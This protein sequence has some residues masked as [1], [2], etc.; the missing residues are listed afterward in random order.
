MED[1]DIFTDEINF[2]KPVYT[3]IL[4]DFVKDVPATPS[5]A[6][7]QSAQRLLAEECLLENKEEC[8]FHFSESVSA[9]VRSLAVYREDQHEIT[10]AD[11]IK[12][13]APFTNICDRV[14][15]K[16][17][18]KEDDLLNTILSEGVKTLKLRSNEEIPF[19]KKYMRFG[20]HNNVKNLLKILNELPKEW[21]IVQLTAR[22]NP[23]ENV[24]PFSEYRTDIDGIFL[25]IL[26]N[27]YTDKPLTVLVP[28]NVT[29]EGELPLFKELYSILEDNYN[30]IDKAQYLNNK[31]L[32]RN[33]WS[34]RED[35]D[36]RIKSVIN[37]M[38]K[39][40]LGG[41]CSMLTGKLSDSKLRDRII[42]FVDSA[43][44]DWGF[45][46]LTAKQKIL[47][48][49]L[50]DCSPVL[51][52]QQIKSCIRQILTE[53]G[54]NEEL[55]NVRNSIKCQSC[56]NEFR[57][58]NE[59]CIKC[60]SQCFEE[61]HKFTLVDGIKAF[62][63]VA[64]KFK[65]D[66]QW[67]DLKK[68]KRGPVI[69]IVDEMLDTFPWESLPALNQQPISRIENIHF[70]YSLFKT[71]EESIKNGYFVTKS[72]I[73]RYVINPGQDLQRMQLRMES[74]I[75]Y[76]CG[77]WEGRVAEPPAPGELLNYLT[78][79]DIFLYCGHGDGCG[80]V[81][82]GSGIGA[83]AGRC[84]CLLSGCGSVRLSGG[85][86]RAPPAGPH[87]H[88]HVAKC[89]CVVGMLWEV[90][91]LEVDKVV[92]TLVALSVASE[93]PLDWRHVGK[94]K[95]SQGEIDVSVEQK[96]RTPPE[97][98]LLRAICRAKQATNFLMIS[99]SIVARGLPIKIIDSNPPNSS[100]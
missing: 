40:W 63:Q 34:R 98:N 33:Y 3:N 19:H 53:N 16:S 5:S 36:L 37:V 8:E 41:W 47:L 61:I 73:G 91:D 75:K 93:A 86:G 76:W 28:A 18:D 52:S 83:G 1:F 39:D 87:H 90:T 31:R 80:S 51:Q 13:I 57:F 72:E 94:T 92:S 55:R 58:P 54:N 100:V 64:L 97:R 88:L 50:M 29:K 66:D 84:V 65:D 67:A 2:M 96:P 71:H 79:A 32:I 23:K 49:N 59:L 24:K 99:T 77:K 82:V 12:L 74:F 9:A 60:L 4:H 30:I 6:N 69:I 15:T 43:I 70:L 17:L 85:E 62:S 68:A 44:S 95:W 78:E 46:K 25:S 42:H 11:K 27:N 48:Y 20:P 7:Y 26:T 56:S 89:P 21:T 81:C 22:Y 10:G 14:E 38:D 45:I 35:I